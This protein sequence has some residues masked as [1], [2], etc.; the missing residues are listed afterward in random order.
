MVILNL[1]PR[2]FQMYYPSFVR[3]LGAIP[4][5]VRLVSLVLECISVALLALHQREG[6]GYTTDY[7]IVS[8]FVFSIGPHISSLAHIQSQLSYLILVDSIEIVFLF[9]QVRGWPLPAPTILIAEDIIGC[10]MLICSRDWHGLWYWHG[11]YYSLSHEIGMGMLVTL[12]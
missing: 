2:S 12:P 3:R 7:M 5:L 6:E 1:V 10:L 8:Y 4:G 9:G 11:P